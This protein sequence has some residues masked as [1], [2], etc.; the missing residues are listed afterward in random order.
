MS[1]RKIVIQLQD[2]KILLEAGIAAQKILFSALTEEVRPLVEALD[3]GSMCFYLQDGECPLAIVGWKGNKDIGV[4][5]NKK[6]CQYLL[7][8]LV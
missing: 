8:K 2:M 6:Q 1:K 3:R 4:V 7:N 5:V